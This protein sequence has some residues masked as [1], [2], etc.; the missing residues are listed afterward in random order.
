MT[1]SLFMGSDVKSMRLQKAYNQSVSIELT[2]IYK[3]LSSV[4]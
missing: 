4:V 1:E 3:S 2:T